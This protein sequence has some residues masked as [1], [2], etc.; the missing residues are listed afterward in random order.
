MN[1]RK[2]RNRTSVSPGIVAALVL[3]CGVAACDG[4]T[5]GS[6]VEPGVGIHADGRSIGIGETRSQVVSRL[7]PPATA[8]DLGPSGVLLAYP[9]RHVSC[10]LSGPEDGATVTA[11]YLSA[12]FPGITAGGIG[13]GSPRADVAAQYP[14]PAI[15]PFLATWRDSSG[16]A[17]D[18]DGD[19]VASITVYGSGNP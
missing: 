4:V 13:L 19:V 3:A 10:L 18:W 5:R 1:A 11:I 14:S 15:D 6:S 8:H 7:G 2:C 16:I 9:D 12:G 17:F